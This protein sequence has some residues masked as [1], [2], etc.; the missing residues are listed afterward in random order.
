MMLLK[1]TRVMNFDGALRGMRNPLESWAKADSIFAKEHGSFADPVLVKMGKNDL[2]LA[3]RLALAGSDHG[4]FLRQ[5]FVCVDITAPLYWWKDFD[6]YKVGTVANSTS[7]MHKLGSRGL[8]A[9]D[10]SWDEEEFDSL[11]HLDV[12][13]KATVTSEREFT[14]SWLN[15][16]IRLWKTIQGA[17]KDT[18]DREEQRRLRQYAK[19]VWR[20]FI[21]DLP[22]SFNQ[23]RTVTLNYENLRN[24]YQ[25]RKNHKLVEFHVLCK[26]IGE[27]PYSELITTPRVTPK[28]KHQAELISTLNED[29][30]DSLRVI[31]EL[32]PVLFI[33]E[34]EKLAE[35]LLEIEC[36]LSHSL[37]ILQS[38][39][40]ID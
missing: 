26:W 5:I 6:T 36:K 3:N 1:E 39:S 2:D 18:T 21:Q 19:R 27:L 13:D 25:A 12:T 15:R 4:K 24:I 11:G 40:P 32:S 14:L 23:T 35:A 29:I 38:P 10:F 22:S 31:S 16:R 33:S 17:V 8:V 30:K 34:P 28:E 7:T 20:R 9:E 37:G